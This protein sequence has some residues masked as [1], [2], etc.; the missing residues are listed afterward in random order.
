MHKIMIIYM[1]SFWTNFNSFK[2]FERNYL[3]Y[4][5][6]PEIHKS[7]RI[8]HMYNKNDVIRVVIKFHV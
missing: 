3:H 1:K 4:P 2:N 8:L 7:N 6:N 5:F